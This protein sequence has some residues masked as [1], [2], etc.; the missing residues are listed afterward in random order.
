M[1][2]PISKALNLTIPP[3]LK[4]LILLRK[5]ANEVCRDANELINDWNQNVAGKQLSSEETIAKQ[6]RIEQRK[7]DCESTFNNLEEFKS[8]AIYY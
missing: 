2:P 8:R 6:S 4:D 3:R 1:L 5:K 7:Q